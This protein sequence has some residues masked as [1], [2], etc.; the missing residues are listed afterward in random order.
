MLAWFF[1]LE[2]DVTNEFGAEAAGI[3][4]CKVSGINDHPVVE[5]FLFY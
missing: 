5:S 1:K 2:A 3:V 4:E